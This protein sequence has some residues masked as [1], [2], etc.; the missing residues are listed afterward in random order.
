M[1]PKKG[2]KKDEKVDD[3][4]DPI[5]KN[6]VIFNINLEAFHEK[7]H[8]IKIK[9][10]WMNKETMESEPIDAEYLKDWEVIRREGEEEDPE[11]QEAAP[12]KDDKKKAPPKDAKKGAMDEI[13]DPVPTVVSYTK[14][15]EESPFTFTEDLAKAWSNF[16]MKIEV[17]EYNRETSEDDLKDT[18]EV[19]LSYFLFPESPINDSW[20]FENV[21]IYSLN[22]L[23]LSITT[24]QPLLSEFIRKKLNPLQ[25]FILAAKDVP[26]KTDLKYLPVYTVAKFVD[27]TEYNT[28]GLPQ[29][30]FCKWMHKHVILV[31]E[32]D[33]VEFGEKLASRTLDL[34]LHD[35]DEEIKEGQPEAKFSYGLAKFHLKDL[36][37]PHCNNMK[38]RSDVF[39][40]SYFR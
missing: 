3:G 27:G 26:A 13:D 32:K 34:E 10:S 14:S 22:Y 2:A 16:I 17:Y 35:C 8:F 40:V 4:G 28:S 12:G 33:P 25:I 18:L 1:P 24:D 31:G 20:N 30:D 39:P 5:P 23:K 15:Y 6:D 7:G 38:L 19:D 9:Y 37:N 29:S 11:A 21:K 36:L